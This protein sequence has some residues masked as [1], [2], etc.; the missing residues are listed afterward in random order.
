[1]KTLCNNCYYLE[2]VDFGDGRGKSYCRKLFEH[3][4]NYAIRCRHYQPINQPS[5]NDM[6]QSAYILTKSKKIGYITPQLTFDEPEDKVRRHI[7]DGDR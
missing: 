1:M 6:Y 3:L 5:L 2:Q 4:K 7:D